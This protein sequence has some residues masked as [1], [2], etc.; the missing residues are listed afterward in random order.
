MLQPFWHIFQYTQDKEFLSKRAYPMMR[1]GALFYA[2]YVKKGDDGCYHVVPTTSQEHWGFTPKFRLNRDSVGAL[3][4]VKYHLKACIQAAEILS[5]DTDKREEWREIVEHLAPYPTLTTDQGPVFCDV[6]DAPRL[7]NY[8]NTANL[9]MVLWAEDISLDS[10]PKLLEM[11]RRSYRAIPD[12]E[13]SVR[14]GYLRQIRLYLGMSE[15][16][17]LSPQGRVLSWPG[18]IHLYAGV[19]KGRAVNDQ[20]SGLLAI[21]AFE[22]SAAHVGKNIRRV[23]IKSRVGG[24]CRVKNPW[25]PEDV[26]VMEGNSRE[27]VNHH[28]DGDTIVFDTQPGRTYSLLSPAERHLARGGSHTFRPEVDYRR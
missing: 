8:N 14:K 13:R 2:D 4:F 15:K 12:K 11:A 5:V 19:P 18:R 17:D 10:P 22:V 7:L 25:Q 16:L 6:R 1:E 3:S 20:F 26:L 21:G 9:I 24:P 27:I 23:Q 28:M